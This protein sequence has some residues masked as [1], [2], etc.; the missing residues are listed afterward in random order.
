[1]DPDALRDEVGEWVREG[2]ISEDQAT[3][4][5]SRYESVEP[6]RSRAV[7]ALS[8]VGVALVFVGVTWFLAT[9]WQD[10]PRVLRAIVLVA[11]PGLAYAGGILTYPKQSPRIGHA[12]MILGAILV[13]PS[14][15][16]LGDLVEIDIATV[17]ILLGWTIFALPTGHLL[18][19]R[20]GT[21]FGLLI[22]SGLVIELSEPAD[23]APVVGLLGLILFALGHT[24]QTKSTWVY[25][26]GGVALAIA[27]LL[28]LTTWEGR[29]DRF[30]IEGTVPL[31]GA[32]VGAI[33]GTMWLYQR[34]D[35][36]AFEWMI[37]GLVAIVVSVA[38][39]TL[40][41]DSIPHGIGFLGT[42]TGSLL[43]LV[44]TGHLG[45]RTQS[46]TL[47]DVAVVGALLQTLS[48]VAATIV[49]A[50]S[51]AVALILAG[52]ILLL[53]GLGL[54]RGRRSLLESITSD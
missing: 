27:A 5:L 14:L 42:H 30:A 26:V 15:F 39:A 47:I 12:L 46:K 43:L 25:R 24:R 18:D 45:L 29:F 17:W 4:I 32:I 13:G 51:G 19:S 44:A 40:A 2:I 16:L 38:T 22:L 48:F 33:G 28:L 54:E 6:E 11:A 20:P 37:A 21:A 10:L 23:P 35:R 31:A 3:E 8:L 1:M 50:L 41:P 7:I 36:A 49:D 53:I 34:G 9:N 52:V